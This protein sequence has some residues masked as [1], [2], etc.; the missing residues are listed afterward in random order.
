[1]RKITTKLSNL[2]KLFDVEEYEKEFE[3]NEDI[4]IEALDGEYVRIDYLVKKKTPMIKCSIEDI[5]DSYICAEKHIIMTPEGWKFMIDSDVVLD[6]NGVERRVKSKENMGIQDSYDV[7]IDNPHTYVTSNG[8]VHH[9]TFLAMMRAIEEVLDKSTPYKQVVVIRSTVPSRE[10]GFLP[11]TEE[12]KIA[13]YELPYR[14]IAQTLFNRPDAWDRL[15]EQGHARFI[16]SSFVRG[17]SIDDSIIIVEEAQ[18]YT[19]Q[20]LSSVIT[21]TGHR[22]K[23]IFT[24]DLF[25][26]DLVRQKNDQSGLE[27]ILDVLRSMEEFQEIYFTPDDIVRSSLVKKFIQACAKKG[28]LPG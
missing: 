15:K 20:E 2:H 28:L 14:E 13:I 8:L 3:L 19:W 22:S 9:N 18:N 16:S 6:K 10:I 17:I 11:G 24:G 25:Q 23:I 4:F 12:E 7:S 1:M 21:R 26:N 5:D 27:M